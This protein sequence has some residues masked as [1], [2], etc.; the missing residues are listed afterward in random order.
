MTY[1]LQPL[2]YAYDALEPYI[3]EAT[4]KLHYTKH[5]QA[6]IDNLNKAL[7]KYP[8]LQ[9]KTLLELLLAINSL[10]DSLAH[11]IRNNGG[12]HLNH[13]L[14]WLIME[15]QSRQE[16]QGALADALH[17][18]FGSFDAFKSKF[19]E[20]AKTIFGSGWAW[21]AVDPHR[22]LIV[23]ATTNQD[24]PLQ[25]GLIPILCL[26]VWEHAYYLKYNNKRFDYIDAW[27]Q[28]VNWPQ[29]EENYAFVCDHTP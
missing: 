19:N 6:Y 8:S 28:V 9:S 27:W 5:H 20:C 26:D 10:P 12:G 18:T 7:E 13:S 3:D 23:D 11:T 4:M 14:F 2:P 1:T 24:T 16:P 29:V 15:P 21:L 17:K 22:N 25:R